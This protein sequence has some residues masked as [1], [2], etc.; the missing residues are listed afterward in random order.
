MK[1]REPIIKNQNLTPTNNCQKKNKIIDKQ[2][3][4][5]IVNNINVG[6]ED[7]VGM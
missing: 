6:F 1:P 3:S 4:G 7:I 2:V 5:L